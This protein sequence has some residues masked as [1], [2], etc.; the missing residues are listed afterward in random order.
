M[1]KT[2]QKKA[3]QKRTKA[4]EIPR[5]SILRK[6]I[7]YLLG[8]PV[9]ILYG[10]SYEGM[11]N[12]PDEP[13]FLMANHRSMLDL[14]AIQ[15]VLPRWVY[16]IAKRSLFDIPVVGWVVRRLGAIP[17]E[18]NQKDLL[19]VRTVLRLARAG[20]S[21]GIFPQGTRVKEEDLYKVLPHGNTANLAAHAKLPIVPVVFARPWKLFRRQRVI[22]GEPFYISVPEDK[23]NRK[24]EYNRIMLGIMRDIFK[25]ADID[26]LPAPDA[27]IENSAKKT[28]KFK[29]K[30]PVNEDRAG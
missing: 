11:E 24:Q 30:E 7:A 25:L 19:T 22:F 8:F 27:R 10:V 9:R 29:G 28:D 15:Y 3:E 1:A 23:E 5:K 18:R 4:Y 14:M 16:W 12:I 13:F 17:L 6:P 26:W 20:L 2:K 21:I